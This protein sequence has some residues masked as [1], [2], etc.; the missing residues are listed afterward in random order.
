MISLGFDA[1]ST[2]VGFAFTEDKKI[3]DAGFIDISKIKTNREKANYVFSTIDKNP[4]TA[5]VGRIGL[6]GSLS[7]FG[8]PSNRSVVILLARWNA[9]FEHMLN[10]HYKVPVHLVNVL[11]ARKQVF[12][13]ATMKGVKPKPYVKLMLDQMYDMTQWQTKNKKGNIDKRVEDVYDGI[14]ISLYNP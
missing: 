10:D 12:G 11:S 3:L 4:L 5:K 6:E 14:V 8:G 2:V 1:S 13:K 9:I 7:G